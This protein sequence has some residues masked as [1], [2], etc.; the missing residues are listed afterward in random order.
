MVANDQ[1]EPLAASHGRRP[2]VDAALLHAWLSGRSI[3]RGVPPPV[4][5]HGGFRVDTN[6]PTE[7]SRWVFP[8]IMPEIARLARTIHA[9]RLFVKLCGTDADLR[10]QLPGGW[11]LHAPAFF[12]QSGGAPVAD[13]TPPGYRVECESAGAQFKVRVLTMDDGLAASGYGGEIDDAFVY[14]R[15]VTAPDHRRR[16][17]GR[18]V[19]ATL[20]SM[21]RNAGAAELLVATP[22][23]RALYERLGWRVL[24][25]YATASRAPA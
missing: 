22:E 7:R 2:G 16:G 4:P 15:I 10:S 23:G 24:S 1:I 3:A 14:D 18:I 6:S 5:D 20:Q 12:M 8:W 11:H 21:R 19:M 25:P 17:L 13:R 9:P